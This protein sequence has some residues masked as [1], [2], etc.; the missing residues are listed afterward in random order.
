MTKRDDRERQ[1]KTT[2]ERYGEDHFKKIGAEGGKKSTGKFD[3]ERGR[4]AV[5]R[6]WEKYR[7]EQDNTTGKEQENGKET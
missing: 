2:R 4:K 5:Q 7:S 3:S 1:V 6:R